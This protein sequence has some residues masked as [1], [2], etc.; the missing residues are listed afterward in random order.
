MKR[1]QCAEDLERPSLHR[2]GAENRTALIVAFALRNNPGDM[3]NATIGDSL[4]VQAVITRATSHPAD[5]CPRGLALRQR[6]LAPGYGQPS[7]PE[8]AHLKVSPSRDTHWYASGQSGNRS[9]MET[10]PAGLTFIRP[11]LSLEIVAIAQS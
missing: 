10:A 2:P 3:G 7:C 6:A 8:G 4:N 11:G 9:S 5:L 1:V